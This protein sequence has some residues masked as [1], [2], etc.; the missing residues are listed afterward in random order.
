MGQEKVLYKR[1]L[2]VQLHRRCCWRCAQSGMIA[3][4]E[5]SRVHIHLNTKHLI[6]IVGHLLGRG[7]RAGLVVT[8]S[9]AAQSTKRHKPTKTHSQTPSAMV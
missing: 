5:G 7:Q 8:L 1:N 4:R 2:R 3:H 6:E 9:L